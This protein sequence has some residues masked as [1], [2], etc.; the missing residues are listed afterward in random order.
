MIAISHVFTKLSRDS[1]DIE[2]TK[3][4]SR[5]KNFNVW[6]ENILSGINDKLDI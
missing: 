2:K 5:D 3:L 6:E 4:N 1:E